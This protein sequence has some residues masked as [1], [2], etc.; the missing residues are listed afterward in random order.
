RNDSVTTGLKCAPETG[1]SAVMSTNRMAPVA[2]ALASSASAS[3]PPAK[4]SAMMPE[5]T[6]VATRSP[7]PAASA[8]RRSAREGAG[9]TLGSARLVLLA[10]D[11]VEALL[12]RE[13]V[14]R[15]ERKIDED[16]D[17]VG[18]HAVR[19]GEGGAL[20]RLAPR[21]GGGIGQT[22]MCGHR[23]ARPDR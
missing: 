9:L 16:R 2:S 5:P 11:L 15:G 14:E 10:A 18:Q 4:R 13:L 6:T 19:V 3:F 23:L 8:A 1:A 7:V 22:P 17:A 20:L 21:H 12:Q